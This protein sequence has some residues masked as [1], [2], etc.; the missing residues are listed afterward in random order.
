MQDISID[1]A[2]AGD[3]E[4]MAD[5]LTELFTQEQDFQP[6]RDKQRRGLQSILDNPAM[7]RLFVVRVGGRVVGMA[8]LLITVST[9]EGAPVALLEDVIVSAGHRGRGLGRQLLEHVIAWVGAAGM[10]RITLLTDADNY[11]AQATYGR[12]GFALSAMRVMRRPLP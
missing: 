9:A 2:Q 10:A 5:L 8:N 4:A 11:R 3:V 12:L 7:G 1:F 6:D